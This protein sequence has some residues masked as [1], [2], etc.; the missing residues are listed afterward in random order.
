MRKL[1]PFHNC[2][3]CGCYDTL[4]MPDKV[5]N[6]RPIEDDLRQQLLGKTEELKRERMP[7]DVLDTL[8][9]S[10]HY[11]EYG[12]SADKRALEWLRNRRDERA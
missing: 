11:G 3:T 12:K 4:D 1:C 2:D 7:N 8:M 10:I 9:N 6:K 5:W